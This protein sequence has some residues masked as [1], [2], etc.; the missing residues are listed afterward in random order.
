MDRDRAAIMGIV[1]E[2]QNSV[3]GIHI[4]DR[5]KPAYWPNDITN[6]NNLEFL[7]CGNL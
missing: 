7:P 3:Y 6:I 2:N 5:E 4:Q 1:Y